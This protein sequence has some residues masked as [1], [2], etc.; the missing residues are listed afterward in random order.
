MV[1]YDH[2][3][4]TLGVGRLIVVT[5][6]RFEDTIGSS[7]TG[8]KLLGYMVVA[9]SILPHIGLEAVNIIEEEW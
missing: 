6:C 3:C 4:L 5:G 8:R 1:D 9:P 2:R 7:P